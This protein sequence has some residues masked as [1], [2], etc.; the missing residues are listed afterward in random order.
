MSEQQEGMEQM[1][2]RFQGKKGDKGDQGE[3]GESRLPG[4]QAWAIVV[5]VVIIFVS[6]GASL[7][8]SAREIGQNNQKWCATMSLLD[9]ERPPPGSAASNPSRAYEQKLYADFHRLRGQLG[10]G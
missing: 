9:A 3:K 2:S 1:V 8:L 10:C 4:R 6:S 5:L 7:I